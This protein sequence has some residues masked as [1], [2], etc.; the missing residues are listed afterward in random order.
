MI[1][2]PQTPI[3]LDDI[4]LPDS[5]I[6]RVNDEEKDMLISEPTQGLGLRELKIAGII[7]C[8]VLALCVPKIYLANTIYYLSKEISLLQT[9]HDMLLDENKRLKHDVEDLKYKF[10]ILQEF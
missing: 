5:H 9:H 1:K 2:Q 3:R 7:L 4:I 6:E 8:A 10:I